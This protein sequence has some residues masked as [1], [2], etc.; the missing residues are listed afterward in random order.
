MTVAL[1]IINKVI[2]VMQKISGSSHD[3]THHPASHQVI[4]GLTCGKSYGYLMYLVRIWMLLPVTCK[5]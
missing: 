5:A 2:S 1:S 4:I 3:H